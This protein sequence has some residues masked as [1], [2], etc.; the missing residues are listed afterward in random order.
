MDLVSVIV[1]TKNSARTIDACLRS[2]RNQTY[3]PIEIVVVDNHSTD[4][5]ADIAAKYA[6]R[7]LQAG[8]ER[9]AQ[10][11]AGIRASRGE[12]VCILDSDMILHD[13]V[14]AKA[15]TVISPRSQAVAIPEQSFGSGFWSACKVAERECY[16]DDQV[17]AGARFFTRRLLDQ[18]GLYDEALTGGED[19]DLSIRAT[20][21]G[22]LV[23]APALI[24]HDEGR[25][26]LWGLCKKKFYYG[27]SVRDFIKKH[28]KQALARVTP[29]R[30]SLV[31][32]AGRLFKN[33]LIGAGVVVMKSCEFAALGCGIVLNRRPPPEAVYRASTASRGE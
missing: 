10:R 4:G 6:D 27:A 23:F 28:G 1:T 17:T 21:N 25:Q 2:I 11:N 26:T 33:P 16:V 30:P 18:V 14:I 3:R 5:T 8:P 32:G 22:E 29:L 13:D 20:K 7:F 24:L 12:Y 31:R 9:S 15:M 19:W